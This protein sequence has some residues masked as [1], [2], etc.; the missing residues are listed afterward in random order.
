M[1]NLGGASLRQGIYLSDVQKISDDGIKFNLLRCS[2]NLS[3]PTDNFRPVDHE[4]I[5]AVNE[6]SSQY[7]KKPAPLNHVLA[8]IYNNSVKTDNK[9]QQKKAVIKLHSD[10]TKDMPTNS[11]IT[12][13]TFYDGVGDG[14]INATR[15][16]YDYYYKNNS[17]LTK[18]HFK[19]KNVVDD[20][21]LVKDF[22]LTLY[23]NSVFLIP[24]STNRLYQ[25][26]IVPSILPI[27]RIPT[28]LGYV[29]RCSNTVAI[30]TGG[31]T[32]IDRSGR[33]TPLV[34]MTKED[35]QY[36]KQL[37]LR[38]NKSIDVVSYDG[39]NYSM[40]SGDYKKPIV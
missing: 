12:F 36:L 22:S 37:Y 30:H 19:L 5:A 34:E 28:R 4:I 25:H 26:E 24:L 32:Y 38:E 29:I 16:N 33:L 14:Q 17:V 27:N 8:Q 21:T 6:I 31:K 20:K 15:C 7:F 35:G 9:V 23:P 39:I 11:L 40:N 3:G 2:T 18:L 1:G 13:A 10:K